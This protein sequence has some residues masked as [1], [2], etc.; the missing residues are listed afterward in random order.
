MRVQAGY[1][2]CDELPK[3]FGR[4]RCAPNHLSGESHATTPFGRL[5]AGFQARAAVLHGFTAIGTPVTA[6]ARSLCPGKG[7]MR[8]AADLCNRDARIC[9]RIKEHLGLAGTGA[10]SNPRQSRKIT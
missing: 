1:R 7:K 4:I 10:Q 5:M 6:I 2:P 8:T 3:P 9:P